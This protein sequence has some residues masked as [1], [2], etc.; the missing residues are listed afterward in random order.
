[1]LPDTP[2]EVL[3]RLIEAVEVIAIAGRSDGPRLNLSTWPDPEMARKIRRRRVCTALEVDRAEE[4]LTWFALIEDDDARRALQFEV[5]CKA[6]GGKFSS[7]CEKYGWQRSTVL[8]RNKVVLEKLSKKLRLGEGLRKN[9]ALERFHKTGLK[10][11]SS[12]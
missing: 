11:A 10:A 7:V 3:S 4:A 8:K 6:G 12:R 5:M 9:V 2:E 1:M